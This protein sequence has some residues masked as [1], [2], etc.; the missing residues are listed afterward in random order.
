MDY[1]LISDAQKQQLYGNDF[2]NKEVLIA[3]SEANGLRATKNINISKLN[4][5]T[6]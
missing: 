3:N 4:T 6:V 1:S 2:N 5:R